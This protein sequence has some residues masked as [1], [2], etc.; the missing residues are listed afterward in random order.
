[1]TIL[2]LKLIKLIK[3]INTESILV[4]TRIIVSFE[5]KKAG[6]SLI[7][8]NSEMFSLPLVKDMID[9]LQN[10]LLNGFFENSGS[11][12]TTIKKT[13]N[14]LYDISHKQGE[15]QCEV[16]IK[17]D[18]NISQEMDLFFERTFNRSE[19][20]EVDLSV[21]SDSQKPSVIKMSQEGSSE[22]LVQKLSII[23][24]LRN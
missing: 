3:L 5:N 2:L 14:K 24:A 13:V 18:P 1:M 6:A 22:L 17:I 21:I 7:H 4:M 8:I 23:Q 11:I 9:V 20:I 15:G 10:E 16:D 19:P 12:F